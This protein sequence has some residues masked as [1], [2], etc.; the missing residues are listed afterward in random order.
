VRKKITRYWWL[1]LLAALLCVAGLYRS[2]ALPPGDRAATVKWHPGHYVTIAGHVDGPQFLD[3]HPD[4]LEGSA[5]QG[6]LKKIYWGDVEV[7]PGKYDF[8]AVD[9]LLDILEPHHKSLFVMVLDRTF[10]QGCGPGLPLPQHL[11]D[12]PN[13]H[14]RLDGDRNGCAAA[15]WD[16]GVMG[17]YI[18][19]LRTLGERYDSHAAFQGIALEESALDT[20]VTYD[21]RVYKE[22]L[23]RLF[24][25]LRPALPRSLVLANLNYLNFDGVSH[26]T[27]LGDIAALVARLGGGITTPDSVPSR[28]TPFNAVARRFRG[29]VAIAPMVD[30]TFVDLRRDTATAI[31]RF[32]VENLGANFVFWAPWHRDQEDYLERTVLPALQTLAT[33]TGQPPINRQCPRSLRCATPTTGT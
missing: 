11:Y 27:N 21:K 3:W 15:T 12:R 32:N 19:L 28:G 10:V 20:V 6:V 8:A 29:Q 24:R 13:S 5:V 16:P 4:L 26:E 25:E 17:R 30:S 23:M 9:Q 31:H 18:Q 2:E 14:A 7:A 1:G 33:E 22:Q